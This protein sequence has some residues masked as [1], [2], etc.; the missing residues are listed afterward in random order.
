MGRVEHALGGGSRGRAG[1]TSRYGLNLVLF[2]IV[3]TAV[4]TAGDLGRVLVG[5]MLGASVAAIFGIASP[6]PGIAGRLGSVVLDPNEVA[7]LVSG[8][9][10]AVGVVALYRSAPLVDP[11]AAT[12]VCVR[13]VSGSRRHAAD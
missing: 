10:L 2:V 5:F 7:V 4:R 12:G 13:P 8:R 11:A 9:L 1:S 6:A 3:F